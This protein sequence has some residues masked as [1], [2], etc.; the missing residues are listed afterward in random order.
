MATPART[1]YHCASG[2]KLYAGYW[3]GGKASG[4]ATL[5]DIVASGGVS[6]G[7]PSVLS[8]EATVGYVGVSGTLVGYTPP[9]WLTAL[10]L[11]TWAQ[12]GTKPSSADPKDDPAINPATSTTAPW[13]PYH[14]YVA[15]L[16]GAWSGAVADK[17]RCQVGLSGGGHVGY[18][19]DETYWQDLL[20]DAAAFARRGYPSGSFQ[21]PL[22]VGQD[23]RD[24][25]PGDPSLDPIGRHKAA[26]TYNLQVLDG[27]GNLVQ[28]PGG[29][30]TANTGGSGSPQLK[31]RKFDRV[32]QDWL[33]SP[34]FD[35]QNSDD[36]AGSAVYHPGTNTIWVA[37]GRYLLRYNATTGAK[38]GVF[39]GGS[40]P[41]AHYSTLKLDTR[42]DIITMWLTSADSPFTNVIYFD[43][44]LATPVMHNTVQAAPSTFWSPNG[45]D[46]DPVDDDYKIWTGGSSLTV[47]KP[48]A[49]GWDTNTW[50]SSTLANS[51][52]PSA[53]HA[54]GT[55]N[56][57]FTFDRLGIVWLLNSSDEKPWVLRLR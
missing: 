13:D 51:G 35:A 14:A 30:L 17:V 6:G 29:Y 53:P 16:S 45:I 47:I 26:H 22:G 39:F 2:G 7:Q 46:Y 8:D 54:N 28:M 40:G 37:Q 24:A 19:G 48:P 33:A 15:N 21:F 50:L 12:I 38:T 23:I 20:T 10:P 56:R 9:A 57:F 25:Y 27:D 32:T 44:N 34:V 31:G 55:F 42:R 49:T 18:C 11:R 4:G 3:P 1:D 52:T 43:P 5:A 36:N 41:Y